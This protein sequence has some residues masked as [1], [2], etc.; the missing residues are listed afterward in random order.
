MRNLIVIL[1]IASGAWAQDASPAAVTV[2]DEALARGL[3]SAF[4]C[5]E[6]PIGTKKLSDEDKAAFKQLESQGLVTLRDAEDGAV[7]L[8]PTKLALDHK[9]AALSRRDAVVVRL[10]RCEITKIVKNDPY[11]G[12]KL[13][14]SSDYRFVM[15][16]YRVVPTPLAKLIDTNCPTKERKFRAIVE[17]NPFS[18]KHAVKRADWGEPD[19]DGWKSAT[20]E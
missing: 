7:A 1:A 4:N 8:A 16:T 3:E 6:L 11:T 15:G 12:K 5:A 10:G 13:P 20:V 14:Q 19:E 18:G 17:V 2:L 9:D